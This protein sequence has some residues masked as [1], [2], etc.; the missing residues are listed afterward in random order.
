[1]PVG[2][3]LDTAEAPLFDMSASIGLRRQLRDKRG[4][5]AFV[6]SINSEQFH[7]LRLDN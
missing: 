5:R 4:G 2:F 1:V 6:K 7:H 3:H